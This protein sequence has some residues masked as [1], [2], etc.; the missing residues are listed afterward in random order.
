MRLHL[1]VITG[2]MLLL[3]GLT[4]DLDAQTN[5]QLID[6]AVESYGYDPQTLSQAQRRQLRAAML[7]LFPDK[8]P[9]T[10]QLNRAQAIAV[11]YV[12]LIMRITPGMPAGSGTDNGRFFRSSGCAEAMTLAYELFESAADMTEDERREKLRQA[13]VEASRCGCSEAVELLRYAYERAYNAVLVSRKAF[14]A[15]QHLSDCMI[16]NR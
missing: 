10:Y 11:V 14:E 2:L 9:D 12:G 7:T 1:L 15:K 3:A 13:E 5:R 8:D 6:D 16:N 4:T